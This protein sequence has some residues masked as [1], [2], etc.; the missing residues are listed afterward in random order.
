M[1]VAGVEE[2]N[3]AIYLIAVDEQTGLSHTRSEDRVSRDEA[4]FKA[5]IL[6]VWTTF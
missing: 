5:T 3:T 2:E 6:C 4:H 1:G